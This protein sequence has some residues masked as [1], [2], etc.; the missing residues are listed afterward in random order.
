MR[1]NLFICYLVLCDT[2]QCQQL[3]SFSQIQHC[4]TFEPFTQGPLTGKEQG[5]GHRSLQVFSLADSFSASCELKSKF[6][7]MH[8]QCGGELVSQTE[9][10]GKKLILAHKLIKLW[11]LLTFFFL[12]HGWLFVVAWSAFGLGIRN[13]KWHGS[14]DTNRSEILIQ[15]WQTAAR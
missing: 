15:T 1:E 14:F 6:R 12:L 13:M 4:W 10:T 3:T 5:D 8:R 11:I 7:Q 2:L 9:V